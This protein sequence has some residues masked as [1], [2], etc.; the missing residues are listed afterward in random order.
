MFSL[1]WPASMQ[2]YWNKRKRFGTHTWLLFHCF[3]TQQWPPWRHV[4]THNRKNIG[5]RSEPGVGLGRGEGER[6]SEPGNMPLMPLFLD[7]RFW[8]HALI[9][10]MSSCWQI[11]G[12][13]DSIALF[14]YHAPTIREKI[15]Q[16]TDKF[17][18]CNTNFF[19]RLQ[20]T[21]FAYT[22]APRRAKNMPV[23]CCKKKKKHSKYWAFLILSCDKLQ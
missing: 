14:Q 2:I 20:L 10:Q 3:G 6:A 16:N 23:F 18:A 8:Y 1:T 21:R 12:A 13:V 19:A 22:S 5:K 4:K 7:T 15:F 11:R 9:G 17:V